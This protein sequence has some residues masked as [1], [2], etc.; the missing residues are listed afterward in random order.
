[1]EAA[2]YTECFNLPEGE[3]ILCAGTVG[4]PDLLIA[5]GLRGAVYDHP[6]YVAYVCPHR[7]LLIPALATETGMTRRTR[8]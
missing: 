5:S 2:G 8:V 4:S 3:V 7:P 6:S 1:M